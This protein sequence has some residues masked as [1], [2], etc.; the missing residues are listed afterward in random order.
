MSKPVH[1][2]NQTY[3]ILKSHQINGE[4]VDAVIKRLLNVVTINDI[5]VKSETTGDDVPKH[6]KYYD[7][8]NSGYIR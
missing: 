8:T 6:N 5:T 1:L 4:T 7:D 3:M 2:S